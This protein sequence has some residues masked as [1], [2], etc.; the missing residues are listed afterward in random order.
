MDTQE[1]SKWE[2]WERE[3]YQTG[4]FYISPY[5]MTVIKNYIEGG[6]QPGSFLTA[7]ICNDLR[8]VINQA[9]WDE[10]MR[11]I[12]AFVIFFCNKAPAD[13]WGS[14]E[15]MELWIEKKRREREVK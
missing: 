1:I 9:G 5:M 7:V 15:K 13:C 4:R 2:T 6:Y 14:Q 8:G 12:P 3:G 11:N 10:N